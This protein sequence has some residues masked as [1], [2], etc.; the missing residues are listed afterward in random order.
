MRALGKWRDSW[1]IEVLNFTTH[2]S[3]YALDSE[4]ENC[5]GKE[6]LGRMGPMFM[7][8][9]RIVHDQLNVNNCVS[10]SGDIGAL[11]LDSIFSGLMFPM[12]TIM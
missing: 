6:K 8:S 5:S 3:N 7:P 11:A 2:K 10:N 1:N 4:S 9:D 12:C